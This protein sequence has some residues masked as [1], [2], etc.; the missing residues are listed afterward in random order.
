[1]QLKENMR[2]GQRKIGQ[3]GI[4]GMGVMGSALA[5]NFA[6][7]GVETSVY[8][9][10]EA[11]TRQ[12]VSKFGNKLIKGIFSLGELVESL[13][14]PRKILLMVTAGKAVDAV[15]EELGLLLSPGDIVVD[16]GNSHFRDT[17]HRAGIWRGKKINFVGLGV[18]GGGHGALV[19]PSMMFG[20]P[21]E[22][23][24]GI[25]GVLELVAAKDASGK[26]CVAC[27]GAD[28]AGHYVKMIHNGIEY[29][30][31]QVLAEIYDVARKA[32]KLVEPEIVALFERMLAG[33]T[34]SFL[35]KAATEVLKK[36]S[37]SDYLVDKI[38]DEAEQQGTGQWTVAEGFGEQLPIPSIIGAEQA[39]E[40]SILKNLRVKL[41]KKY[42][43]DS[44]DNIGFVFKASDVA[45]FG[46]IIAH[47]QGFHL[48][49][50]ETREFGWGT[51][52]A[53]VC[54]V[55]R[56]GSILE[57]DLLDD[58]RRAFVTDPGIEHLLENK[59]IVAQLGSCC[60][61]VRSFVGAAVKCGV[62][63]PVLSSMLAY[64]DGIT[65]ENSPANLIQGMR[66]YFGAHGFQRT[67]KKGD[68]TENWQIE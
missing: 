21:M 41:S 67:D 56:N 24:R 11:V 63:V 6:S 68:F 8:N 47:A 38:L 20:G 15:M 12:F 34:R 50:R 39:R 5:R 25:R 59:E 10:T 54:R 2:S 66:D 48:M 30:V 22:A 46:M 33:K 49:A 7:K 64:F 42:L 4:V 1:M 14:M 61:E 51:D 52:L 40:L 58:I 43:A 57:A 62:A 19:G 9:R 36:K 31:M 13:E 45:L 28:G 29:S 23:W 37:G 32:Q 26:A 17:M 35:V 53:E 27:F 3:I 55:W 44:G 60:A 16:G 18:S 65:E